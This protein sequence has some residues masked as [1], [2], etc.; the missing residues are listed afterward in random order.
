[1]AAFIR[2]VEVVNSPLLKGMEL[3]KNVLQGDGRGWFRIGLVWSKVNQGGSMDACTVSDGCSLWGWVRGWEWDWLGVKVSVRNGWV[4]CPLEPLVGQLL[5]EGL[6]RW[7]EPPFP[8][9]VSGC[10]PWA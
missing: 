3:S 10:E 4:L 5:E 8:K 1:M 6:C 7:M 9:W 2:G